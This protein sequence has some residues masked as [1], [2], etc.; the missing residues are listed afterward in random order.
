MINKERIQCSIIIKTSCILRL[1]ILVI[2][3]S[4]A[5]NKRWVVQPSMNFRMTNEARIQCSFTIKTS[6]ISRLVM[7]VI[8]TRVAANKSGCRPT[9]QVLSDE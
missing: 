5:A 9:Q 4:V 2:Q 3:T 8:Q 6:C 1:D 7:P